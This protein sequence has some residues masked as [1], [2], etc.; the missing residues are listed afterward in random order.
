[1]KRFLKW[2]A[3]T[4][5]VLFVIILLSSWYFASSFN[6][7]L[8]KV[9]SYEVEDLSIPTDSLSVERGRVLSVSCRSCHGVDL[10]GKVFFDD[11]NAGTLPSSNLT[12]AK[13]SQT[14]NYTNRDFVKA[15]RHGLN[16]E[17]KRIMIM[18]CKSYANMSDVDLGCLI[19]FINTLPKVENSLGERKFTYL[20]QAM[21]GS[22]LF[23][24]IFHYDLLDHEKIK[25]VEHVPVGL[26]LPY[27]S[28]LANVQG[29]TDCH[30]KNFKGGPSPDP[31]SPPAPDLSLT[32]ATGKWSEEEFIQIFR[33]GKTPEGKILNDAFMPFSGL[34]AH[35]DE[36]IKAVYRYIT[37]LEK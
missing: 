37:S 2:T 26:T 28:Y 3:Y 27:G 16:K 18:P 6:K 15:I 23:G 29:C 14:E 4:L 22:G 13:G 20:T 1:M 33:T 30:G 21:A 7:E 5:G 35:S 12:R 32:G 19:A 8:E 36:E 17:G 34:G 31:E 9:I 10:A 24:D 25:H 11:P